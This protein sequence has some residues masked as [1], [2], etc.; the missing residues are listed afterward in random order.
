[1]WP[2]LIHAVHISLRVLLR[3]IYW[4][5]NRNNIAWDFLLSFYPSLLRIFPWLI[6]HP[7]SKLKFSQPSLQCP[8][9]LHYL[10]LWHHLPPFS[11]A[12]STQAPLTSLL[13]FKHIKLCPTPEPLHWL[14]PLPGIFFPQLPA[15]QIPS[16]PSLYSSVTSSMRSSLTTLLITANFLPLLAL[17]IPSSWS[18]FGFS[19]SLMITLCYTR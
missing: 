6:P 13:F 5:N 16:P 8:M 14:Y 10:P 2:W 12:H 4:G 7:E 19:I 11:L 15:W 17:L 3:N 1:M 18:T 9:W